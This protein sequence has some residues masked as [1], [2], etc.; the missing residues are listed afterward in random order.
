MEGR[1]RRLKWRLAL[2]AFRT[3]DPRVARAASRLL[4]S[5]TELM[6]DLEESVDPVLVLRRL[7]ALEAEAESLLARPELAWRR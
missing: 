4:V 6:E 5:L 3:R 2:L 1:V 7:H